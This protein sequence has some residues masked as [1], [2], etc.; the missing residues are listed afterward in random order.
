MEACGFFSFIKPNY[1]QQLCRVIVPPYTSRHLP[2]YTLRHFL[3]LKPK[4]TLYHIVYALIIGHFSMDAIGIFLSFSG[5][6]LSIEVQTSHGSKIAK[7][8]G[9]RGFNSK[10]DNFFVKKFKLLSFDNHIRETRCFPSGF[11]DDQW[12]FRI[13]VRT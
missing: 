10:G 8:T 2:S 13:C 4:V 6:A 3:Y 12:S 5:H 7:L 11:M 1:E 9:E